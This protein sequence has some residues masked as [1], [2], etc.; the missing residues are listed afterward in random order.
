MKIIRSML[1]LRFAV[2]SAFGNFIFADEESFEEIQKSE[3]DSEVE[4]DIDWE[5]NLLPSL[6]WQVDI[7][8]WNESEFIVS[9]DIL[10]DDLS[11][12][13]DD[14]L[15]LKWQNDV[16][17]AFVSLEMVELLSE[18]ELDIVEGLENVEINTPNLII[19]E[20]YRLWNDEWIEI[21]NISDKDFAWEVAIEWVKSASYNVDLQIPKYSSIIISDKDGNWFIDDSYISIIW[22]WL[23]FK[24]KEEISIRL[25][26][27]WVE[28]DSFI[29]DAESVQENYVES[30]WIRPT[31]QKIYNDWREIVPTSSNDS[32]N[33]VWF[34]ANPG[35]IIVQ[36]WTPW[37]WEWQQ[38]PGVS[39]WDYVLILSEVF[40]DDEDE[41]VEIFN[42]WL[43]DFYWDIELS[44]NI[45]W[46]EKI[47][48]IYK[49][50]FIP[51][52][53]FFIIA[54]SDLDF[55]F[56][57]TTDK[58]IIP[59]INEWIYS[60]FIIPDDEELQIS[61]LVDWEEID[62]FF[63]QKYR[64][65]ERDDYGVSFHKI[66]TD[67]GPI[68]TW[69]LSNDDI[70]L[71]EDSRNRANPWVLY[72]YGEEIIDYWKLPEDEPDEPE[73]TEFDCSNVEE[74]LITIDE[75]FWWW[76]RYEPFIEFDIH[77]DLEYEFDSLML[78][79][80]ILS[81]PLE[82]DLNDETETY[83]QEK[84]QKNTKLILT[85]KAWELTEA[86]LIT[87]VLHPDL[88]FNSFIWELKLYWIAWH[89]RQ[90]LDIVK[91]TTWSLERS[92]YH[93]GF[94]HSC[95]DEMDNMMDFSP[96]FD[97]SALK[98]FSATSKWNEKIVE[99]TKYVW[100]WGG[101]SCPSK[102]DLC[103]KSTTENWT[104][105]S[106]SSWNYIFTWES[107]LTWNLDIPWDI[108]LTWN[109]SEFLSGLE[110]ILW[111]IKIISLEPKTP[112]SITLQSFLPYDIDFKNHN[113]YL[114][115][116]TATTKKYIDWIL[117]S[118]SI[119]TFTKSF[120]FVDKWACVYLYSWESMMD[121]YCYS[122]EVEKKEKSEL[123]DIEEFNPSDYQLSIQ[124]VDYDPE[125]N[126]TW[127]EKITIHSESLQTLDLSKIKM[128]VN[129][130]NKK[131]TWILY[132]NSSITLTWTFGFPNSTKD[133]SDV[134]IELFVDDYI[135]DT[136]TY[137]PNTPKLE[138][139][140]LSW[141]LLDLDL[142][143]NVIDSEILLP[144]VKIKSIL[145]NP[146][147][148][149]SEKEEIVL[150][151]T[152]SE[153][154]PESFNFLDLSPD[155]SLLINSKTKKK[156]IWNLTPNM[157]I[158]I[159][160]SFSFPNTASCVSLV[161]SWVE[162]DSFCYSK[163]SDGEKFNLNNTSVSE[164]PV[165]ELSIIKKIS[166]VK[167]WDQLC[168]SYN[169]TLFTCKKIPNSTTEK[170]AKTL[171][172]QNS[173]ILA[174]QDYLKSNYSLLYYNSDIKDYFDLY[175]NAKKSIKSWNNTV[176]RDGRNIAITDISTLF[177]HT[178]QQDAQ[179]YL[180]NQISSFLPDGISSTLLQMK[181]KYKSKLAESDLNFLSIDK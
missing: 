109:E 111:K 150:Q 142:S 157:P 96:W 170:N 91:I 107:I 123:P 14:S 40:Y 108:V 32:S 30:K 28:V 79:W 158:T 31:F 102:E 19:S 144:D 74:D 114:K 181:D 118:Q 41:W 98:Y 66:W 122:T 12:E 153:D 159:K 61:L 49:D 147:W 106:I 13:L 141:D 25:L 128:R 113:Y 117:S 64:V 127:K 104:W 68:V 126:D 52:W 156:L 8:T 140:E 1:A 6:E 87:I 161:Y 51:S 7:F 172:M 86:G 29:V 58:D 39:D 38:E 178:Y 166:L 4:V 65:E 42:I 47:N 55:D 154:F 173:Y 76:D 103:G 155:F 56:S 171:S 10:N 71:S 33:V 5:E 70:N 36:S 139:A 130:T 78:S 145:P 92:T 37:I 57:D 132:P 164:I 175:S 18:T 165:D 143:W 53:D 89:S 124:Y 34:Y 163:P 50:I 59:I 3:S 110:D 115:T 84:L 54:D 112:E 26:Y 101:C 9:S 97:E 134:V 105:N 16:D 82:V 77:E 21:T 2:F 137:N 73:Q 152:P 63:A 35:M 27:S 148:A 133:G 85:T 162:I 43:G 23:N 95:W 62:T 46:E 119:D 151:R 20:V 177:N 75:I 149:D 146:S 120:W 100:W 116:S 15:Y 45:F 93:K 22:A 160:W 125:W 138:N 168:V 24:D 90:L 88:S 176:S 121:S 48:Q 174:L 129:S 135:F 179:T 131:L 99:T 136:Y 81:V 180:I 80:N 11:W 169:K 167:K 67:D 94:L 60:E 17:E 72:T 44:W 83:D 69:S